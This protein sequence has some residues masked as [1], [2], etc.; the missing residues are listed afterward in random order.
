[1]RQRTQRAI[2]LPEGAQIS[3]PE[4][5]D[6]ETLV[7]SLGL[8]GFVEAWAIPT[9]GSPRRLTQSRGGALHPAPAPNGDL[10]FLGLSADGLAVHKSED[11]IP[12][13]VWGLPKLGPEQ[14]I[15]GAPMVQRPPPPQAPDVPPSEPVSPAPY[16]LGPHAL[17][18]VLGAASLPGDG[19]FVELGL[20]A[21]DPT[22]RSTVQALIG[23]QSA[24][25]ASAA[26]TVRIL[27]VDLGLWAWTLDKSRGAA[28]VAEDRVYWNSGYAKAGASLRA[29]SAGNAAAGWAEL[30]HRQWQGQAWLQADLQAS[31]QLQGEVGGQAF[32]TLSAGWASSGLKAGV[33][34][35]AAPELTLG[36]VASSLYAPGWDSWRFYDPAFA[37]GPTAERIN[38]WEAGIGAPA[39]G[40]WLSTRWHTLEGDSAD[41]LGSL[42]LSLDVAT[43]PQP[44]FRMSQSEIQLGLAC[45]LDPVGEQSSEKLCRERQDYTGWVSLTWSP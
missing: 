17:R 20:R 16:Y 7:A 28:L 38:S 1:M 13:T 21:G 2:E 33:G 23:L 34:S 22:G 3:A 25:G 41:T 43:P 9:Q 42:S 45:I 31:G 12:L 5:T 14:P 15:E 19:D 35:A 36:G 18:P 37:T 27:P 40:L 32:G 10:Y 44:F 39:G 6:G 26:W 11:A 29:D 8:H 30:S 24:A 4:W